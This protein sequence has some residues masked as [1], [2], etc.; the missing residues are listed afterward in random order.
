MFF[1]DFKN[2]IAAYN[3]ALKLISELKLWKYFFVPAL[4]GLFV[5]VTVVWTAYGMVDSIGVKISELWPWDILRD[6]MATIGKWLG[7]LLI[8][9]VGLMLYKHVVMAL[10]SP[11][12]GP[13][14]ERIEEHLTG[15]QIEP[16]SFMTLLLRGIRINVRNLVREILLT[17]PLMILGFISVVNLVTTVLIFYIQSYYAGFGNMDY[18][19]ERHLKYSESITFVKKYNGVAVGNGLVFIL[20]LFIPLIGIMLTLPVSTAASTIET[21]KKLDADGKVKLLV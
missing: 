9:V 15:K 16:N 17:M 1:K 6:T 3:T 13:V 5:G 21:L 20:M 14:S 19:M 18:T 12:M 10:S 2:G 11:F 7:G 4:I 8:L